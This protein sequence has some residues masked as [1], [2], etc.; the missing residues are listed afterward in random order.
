MCV[1][2]CVCICA[3][4]RVCKCT[5]VCVYVC[6]CANMCMCVYVC[7]C[8]CVCVCMCVCVCVCA[9]VCMRARVC[10]CVC[11]GVYVCLCVCARM[12]AFSLSTQRLYILCTRNKLKPPLRMSQVEMYMSRRTYP[13]DRARCSIPQILIISVFHSMK[14]VVEIYISRWT[15]PRDTALLQYSTNLAT[16]NQISFSK[17]RLFSYFC[18]VLVQKL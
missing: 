5:C 17:L 7:A 12:C 3:C 13:R 18:T 8:V 4:V 6:M 2:A 11:V 16:V 1:C 10:V 15:Y 9:C 14:F